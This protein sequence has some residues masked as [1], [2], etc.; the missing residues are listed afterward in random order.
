MQWYN[1]KIFI[2]YFNIKFDNEHTIKIKILKFIIITS[3]LL[4]QII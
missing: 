1:I 4:K 3:S 2:L